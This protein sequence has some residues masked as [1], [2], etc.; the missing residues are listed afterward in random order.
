MESINRQIYNSK[1]LFHINNQII[2]WD[3]KKR[4]GMQ[5][6][7]G[8]DK[9][10]FIELNIYE[11]ESYKKEINNEFSSNYTSN[12]DWKVDEDMF[13]EEIYNIHIEELKI[14]ADFISNYISALKGEDLNFIFEITFAGFHV[15]DSSRM[16]TYGRAL[17]EAIISC[18]DEES[19]NLGVLH[20]KK[21]HSPDEIEHR[22]KHYK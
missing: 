12:I 17:I 10:G 21:Y 14:Y 6:W 2:N 3:L 18:F 16:H 1:R 4:H 13:P 20:K 5:K 22:M 11:L 9:Y 19:Y 7:S 15:I 8:H